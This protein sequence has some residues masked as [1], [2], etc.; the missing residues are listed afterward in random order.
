MIDE[1]LDAQFGP[2]RMWASR[3]STVNGRRLVTHSPSSGDEHAVQNRG[4]EQRVVSCSL[5]FDDMPEETDSPRTRFNALL[6]LH[7]AGEPQIFRH[8]L[9]GSYR[10]TIGRF[11]HDLESAIIS[12]D[13]EIVPVGP[14]PELVTAAAGASAPI[15]EEAVSF[16]A[17]QVDDE[18]AAVGLSTPVTEEARVAAAAWQEPDVGA[19]RVLVDVGLVS[20]LIG[21]EIVRLRLSR[22]LALWPAQRAML[23]LGETFAAAARSATA[24]V[25]RLMIVRT[26]RPIAL[27]MLLANIYGAREVRRRRLQALDLND[28]P[29]PGWIPA[30]T[31]LR[32]PQPDPV[33]RAGA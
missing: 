28:I 11:D 17:D 16:A 29:V 12:A 20:E 31:E 22:S 30:G 33:R 27:N 21:T 6:A 1:F 4:L 26:G 7:L 10:A 13:V 2:I 23:V 32:L 24:D 9:L 19:R 25:S 18:L 8:P 5:L 14:L 3:I 15:G